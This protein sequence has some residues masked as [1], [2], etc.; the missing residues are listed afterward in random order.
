L[1][2]PICI[3][4]FLAAQPEATNSSMSRVKSREATQL[5]ATEETP[6]NTPPAA[7]DKP[8]IVSRTAAH[9]PGTMAAS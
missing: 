3:R 4:V 2:R 8:V 6:K 7:P 9:L 1:A 5:V